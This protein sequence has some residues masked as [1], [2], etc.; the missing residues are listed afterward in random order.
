MGTQLHISLSIAQSKRKTPYG[1]S[2]EIDVKEP[3]YTSIQ[4]QIFP[5][6]KTDP[7][8]TPSVADENVFAN[9]LKIPVLTIGAIGGGD[10]TASEW[11]NLR[12]LEKLGTLFTQII[13]LRKSY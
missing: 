4:S 11:I 13:Q 7:I 2:Y 3:F 1:D 8:Y 10:H 9:R 6:Y 12:S 5:Q